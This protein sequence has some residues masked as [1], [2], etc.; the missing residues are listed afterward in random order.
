MRV[1]DVHT[2]TEVFSKDA[3]EEIRYVV[4]CYV[5]KVKSKIMSSK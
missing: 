4:F 5:D 3:G 2:G 1:T